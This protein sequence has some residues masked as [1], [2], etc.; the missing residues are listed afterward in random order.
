MAR[1]AVLIPVA[2][3]VIA[4]VVE[5]KVAMVVV[6]VAIEAVPDVRCGVVWQIRAVLLFLRKEQVVGRSSRGSRWLSA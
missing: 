1:D 4:V 6:V 2:T 3:P 5:M